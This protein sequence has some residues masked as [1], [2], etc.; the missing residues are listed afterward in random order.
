[1][2]FKFS[3]AEQIP[4]STEIIVRRIARNYSNANFQPDQLSVSQCQT[5]CNSIIL[6]HIVQRY[7]SYVVLQILESDYHNR[8]QVFFF[9]SLLEGFLYNS[10]PQ[11]EKASLFVQ[12]PWGYIE[13]ILL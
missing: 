7:Y 4:E 3:E 11:L 9:K 6:E 12:S 13:P 1:M 10:R 5:Q 8:Q 2:K